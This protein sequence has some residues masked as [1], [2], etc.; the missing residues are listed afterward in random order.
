MIWLLRLILGLTHDELVDAAVERTNAD[1]AHVKAIAESVWQNHDA[2]ARW[3]GAGH[4]YALA[5]IVREE[6]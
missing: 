2:K 1:R 3:Y 4:V 6:I 5:R